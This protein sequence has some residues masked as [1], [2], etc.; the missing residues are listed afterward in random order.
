MGKLVEER[1]ELLKVLNS[2]VVDADADNW[3][4][5]DSSHVVVTRENIERSR[6]LLK[7]VVVSKPKRLVC[8]M[9][10][11]E[12]R[13]VPKHHYTCRSC[14]REVCQHLCSGKLVLEGPTS[15]MAINAWATC[16]PCSLREEREP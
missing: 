12:I 4:E 7:K 14:G 8:S 13:T 6:A 5:E 11:G 2:L 1:D 16:G 10:R 15:T 9:C 3:S